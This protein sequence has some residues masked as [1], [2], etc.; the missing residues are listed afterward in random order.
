MADVHKIKDE[1]V[2]SI[3]ALLMGSWLAA[4]QSQAQDVPDSVLAN[5]GALAVRA[6]MALADALPAAQKKAKED[7]EAAKVAEKAEKDA[8]AEHE[9]ALADEH[10]AAAAAA[11]AEAAAHPAAKP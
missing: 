11:K 4:T 3:G 8:A 6:A 5:V 2:Q 1:T 9:K 7:E 10:K